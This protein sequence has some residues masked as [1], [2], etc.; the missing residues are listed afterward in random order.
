MRLVRALALSLVALAV[1]L[2]AS[3]PAEAGDARF[4]PGSITRSTAPPPA[5]T[6]AILRGPDPGIERFDDGRFHR[7]GHQRPIAV[8]PPIVYLSPNRC[9]QPGY[10]TYEWV[11]QTYTY[12]TWVDGQWSTDGYWIDGHYAPSQ[13][14]TG[15]Y[16]PLWA[17][18]Y[19]AGC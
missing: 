14:S 12:S 4:L 11:P 8:I 18:G 1:P 2:L 7:P 10:W 16:Q 19:Y 5:R 15:Y 3:G 17:E 13:Y 9:W 6:P